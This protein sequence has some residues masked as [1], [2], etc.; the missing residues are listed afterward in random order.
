MQINKAE[1]QTKLRNLTT[2]YYRESKKTKSGSGADSKSKWFAF[3]HLQFMRDKTTRH[4]RESGA[5]KE[6]D[7]HVFV[8]YPFNSSRISLTRTEGFF[9]THFNL[10]VVPVGIP[11]TLHCP[12]ANVFVA[13]SSKSNG[14][15]GAYDAF[16]DCLRRRKL[17][18]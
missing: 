10:N 5:M 6:T 3:E 11:S 17:C 18:K 16:D 15:G 14:P 12:G 4:S 2:Q 13:M 1:V 9:G 8:K 7:P